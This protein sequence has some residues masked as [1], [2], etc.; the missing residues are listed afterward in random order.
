MK[1]DAFHYVQLGTAYRLVSGSLQS[2]P[3]P[4]SILL[5]WLWL[6]AFVHTHATT[7]PQLRGLQPVPDEEVIDL[8]GGTQHIPLY[9]M[10]G[11]YGKVSH[12]TCCCPKQPRQGFWCGCQ[13]PM[14][15]WPTGCAAC[16]CPKWM[17]LPRALPS[18]SS[19]TSSR[20]QRWHCCP[21]W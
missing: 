7:H 20:S 21:V 6:S 15:Q 18:S 4:Y 14:R 2:Y 10:S 3:R 13:H 8:Y 11:F 16:Q 1:I 17:F 19:W 12:T 9:Q 5:P